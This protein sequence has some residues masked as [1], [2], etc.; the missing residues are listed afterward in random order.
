MNT[1]TLP[2]VLVL[3]IV[4][5]CG[6]REEGAADLAEDSAATSTSDTSSLSEAGDLAVG[7]GDTAQ[8]VPLVLGRGGVP[9]EELEA[10]TYPLR[11]V[12]RTAQPA[13]VY[14]DAGAGRVVLDTIAPLD[15]TRVDIEVRAAELRLQATDLAGQSL[16]TA[17]VAP[18]ADSLTRWEVPS[19]RSDRL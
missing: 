5:G 7:E 16:I 13:V 6:V 18:V 1:K 3:A 12:N 8:R 14:A 11:L 10:Q 4:A 19:A 9:I 17:T 2:A 15:S